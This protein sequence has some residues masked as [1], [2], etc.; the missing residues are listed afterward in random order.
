M[1]IELAGWP[2]LASRC[3]GLGLLQLRWT[4]PK[5][6]CFSQSRIR[7]EIWFGVRSRVQEAGVHLCDIKVWLLPSVA[8]VPPQRPSGS[9]IAEMEAEISQDM[10]AS[11]QIIDSLPDAVPKSGSPCRCRPARDG[12]QRCA[13]RHF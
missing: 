10:V 7:L 11:E 5:T 2:P 12:H 1:H 4:N 13:V 8:L 6:Q 9:I 3:H